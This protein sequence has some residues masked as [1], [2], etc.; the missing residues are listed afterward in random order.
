MV[1]HSDSELARHICELAIGHDD[2]YVTGIAARLA[3]AFGFLDQADTLSTRM[4]RIDPPKGRALRCEY[5]LRINHAEEALTLARYNYSGSIDAGIALAMCLLET[6]HL[7][8]AKECFE[9]TRETMAAEGC[10][11]RLDEV[12]LAEAVTDACMKDLESARELVG[13][14]ISVTRNEERRHLLL[15]IADALEHRVPLQ[16]IEVRDV[17]VPDVPDVPLEHREPLES[18][19]PCE[20]RGLHTEGCQHLG[21]EHACTA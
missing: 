7:E 16:R 5:C 13:S 9:R 6:Y 3:F 2:P 19:S 11:F 17:Q 20:H 18:E 15:E 21:P 1:D 10:M 8:E 4:L 14:A 12:L